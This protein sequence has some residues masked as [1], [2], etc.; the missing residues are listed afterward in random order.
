MSQAPQYGR[1]VTA[2]ADE[3]LPTGDAVD[4]ATSGAPLP[5]PPLSRAH[6]RPQAVASRRSGLRCHEPHRRRRHALAQG[7]DGRGSSRT[8][9]PIRATSPLSNG[10]STAPSRRGY[11]ATFPDEDVEV[12]DLGWSTELSAHG[13]RLVGRVGIPLVHRDGTHELRVLRAA[14]R[15]SLLDD[16]EVR[17]ALLRAHEWAPG[18]A[19]HRRGGSPRVEANGRVR[20]HRGR[21]PRRHRA[22]APRTSRGHPR[23]S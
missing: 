2:G 7:P 22:M 1:T 13:V 18:N 14:S 6:A 4:A 10:R 11:A 15:G 5:A 8:R 9:S 19:A 16:M 12:G 3:E 20:R 21:P 17:F 23:P